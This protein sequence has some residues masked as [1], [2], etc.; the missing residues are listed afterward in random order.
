MGIVVGVI[1]AT[2]ASM[3]AT[4]ATYYTWLQLQGTSE[5]FKLG[6][7][8]GAT[9]AIEVFAANATNE[10]TLRFLTKDWA[11]KIAGCKH[12]KN[13]ALGQLA[14][15]VFQNAE[16]TF[17]PGTETQSSNSNASQI[18]GDTLDKCPQ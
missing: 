9:D 3:Y 17:P 11:V 16:S 2:V 6:Y 8:A 1:L 14:T 13:F 12:L 7:V 5:T 4:V 15:Y 10:I 18:I